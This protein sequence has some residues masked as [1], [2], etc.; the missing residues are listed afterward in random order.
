MGLIVAICV[1]SILTGASWLF[2]GLAYGVRYGVV[3]GLI[4]GLVGAVAGMLTGVLNNGWS[5]TILDEH[6]LFSPNEGIRRSFKH[7]AFAASLFG[8]LGGLLSGLASALAF[9]L[10]GRL[11]GWPILATGFAL[12]FSAI[13]AF[14]FFLV[15]GGIAWLEHYLLRLYLWRADELPARMVPF[16][17]YAAERLLLRKVDG[18]YLFFHSLLL[19]YFASLSTVHSSAGSVTQPKD[20]RSQPASPKHSR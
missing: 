7:A 19:D 8:P 10:I 16:L 14:Q 18:G 9:G 2:F 4:I 5:N 13:F 17:D 1:L 6:E 11:S 20:T 12:V 3:Y 15:Y